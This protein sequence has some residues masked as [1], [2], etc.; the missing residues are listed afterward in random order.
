MATPIN[1]RDET[2]SEGSRES[3]TSGDSRAATKSLLNSSLISAQSEVI[4]KRQREGF[5][6]PYVSTPVLPRP[7]ETET[8]RLRSTTHDMSAFRAR[9]VRSEIYNDS[10]WSPGRLSRPRSLESLDRLPS[11][12]ST[13]TPGDGETGD[14]LPDKEEVRSAARYLKQPGMKHLTPSAS[15]SGMRKHHWA[16]S[17]PNLSPVVSRKEYP[18]SLEPLPPSPPSPPSPASLARSTPHSSPLPRRK[19]EERPPTGSPRHSPVLARKGNSKFSPSQRDERRSSVPIQNTQ[20]LD[21][22]Q[23]RERSVESAKSKVSVQ[24]IASTGTISSPFDE[25][26]VKRIPVEEGAKNSPQVQALNGGISG[27]HQERQ[28]SGSADRREEPSVSTHRGIQRQVSF[29][30][31][32]NVK[33]AESFRNYNTMPAHVKHARERGASGDQSSVKATEPA[34]NHNSV[35][36]Q[37]R[38]K[39]LGG[40]QNDGPRIIQISQM[41][42][43]PI[44]DTAL[45]GPAHLRERSLS[46]DRNE[47]LRASQR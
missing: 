29:S 45:R 38:E 32:K 3:S 30:E 28:R 33:A 23:V 47:G 27:P 11:S 21:A 20:N 35:A 9:Q 46:N 44:R 10:D 6:S 18:V 7:D 39:S 16:R 41:K 24:V 22:V 34:R 25:D 15:P 31:D 13:L 42:E 2:G 5:M 8:V 4:L 43:G 1:R 36:Q 19:L 37:S 12:S 40:D 17:N 14:G 26:Q